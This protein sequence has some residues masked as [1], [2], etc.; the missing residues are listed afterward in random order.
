LRGSQESRLI[1]AILLLAFV[2]AE[3]IAELWLAQRNTRRLIRKGAI[4][5][6]TAH[7][8]FIVSL[9]AIWMIGLWL[10]AWRLPLHPWWLTAFAVLQVLRGWI[11]LALGDRF[12]TRIITLPGET[13]VRHGPYRFM[14]HPNY[15]VVIGEIA[16]LPLTFGLWQ[17][18]VIFSALNALA[19]AVRI[20]AEDRAL[21]PLR[22][23]H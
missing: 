13:L 10:L 20:P 12:T 18:A 16:V 1:G 14:K 4:E 19:L 22:N 7:Y 17:F 5:H 23:G 15:A 8:P 9:H 11:V 3:R 2:T 21:A 6:A